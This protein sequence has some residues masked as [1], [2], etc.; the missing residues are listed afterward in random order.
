MVIYLT[1]NNY[2]RPFKIK[3]NGNE[4]EIYNNYNDKLI[5]KYKF[6]KKFIG[7]SSGKHYMCSHKVSEA[8]LFNGNSILLQIQQYKYVF[9]G[10]EIYEFKTT[11]QIIKYYSPVGN[12]DVPYPVALGQDNVY[13]MLDKKYIQRQYFTEK[14][15]WEEAYKYFYGYDNKNSKP[16]KL[17]SKLEP[18]KTNFKNVKKINNN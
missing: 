2:A 14:I 17:I 12:N 18:Y 9:I 11:D 3:I 1:H 8:K 16:G 13:F 10:E 6:I 4:A 5:K 15:E 7:K